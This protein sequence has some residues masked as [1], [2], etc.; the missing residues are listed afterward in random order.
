MCSSINK[1]LL[2]INKIVGEENRQKTRSSS[3]KEK[4]REFSNTKKV[5]INKQRQMQE[6]VR[7]Q[8]STDQVGEMENSDTI[9]CQ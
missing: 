1:N 8:F 5:L 3:Q 2:K 9:L 7:C 6:T 4:Y